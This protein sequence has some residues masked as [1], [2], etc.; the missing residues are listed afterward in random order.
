MKLMR[1]AET[2]IGDNELVCYVEFANINVTRNDV[3][4][5]SGAALVVHTGHIV[6][7][8]ATGNLLVWGGFYKWPFTIVNAIGKE[9]HRNSRVSIMDVSVPDCP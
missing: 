4:R 3:P 2:G 5:L 7:N 9:L 8:A 6:Y 1:G